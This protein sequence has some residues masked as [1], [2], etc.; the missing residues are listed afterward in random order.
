MAKF[1]VSSKE[2]KEALMRDLIE[3]GASRAA[4]EE[5]AL[6]GADPENKTIAHVS[7]MIYFTS[8]FEQEWLDRGESGVQEPVRRA[9]LDVF[10]RYLE[11][12]QNIFQIENMIAIVN[13][14]FNLS[15]IYVQLN[16][17]CIERYI[18]PEYTDGSLYKTLAS[19]KVQKT[20]FFTLHVVCMVHSTVLYFPQI[21]MT[22]LS[23]Q[24]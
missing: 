22:F 1:Q 12:F 10:F 13:E 16:I 11:K 19:Y 18:L 14:V 6:Q 9:V 24:N 2:Y 5:A 21:T 3:A 15:N 7:V 8:E 23:F 17:H 20:Y 4:V